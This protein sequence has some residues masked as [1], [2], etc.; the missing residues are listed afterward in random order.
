MSKTVSN[1]SL[2]LVLHV[3]VNKEEKLARV[4]AR[5]QS[6]EHL[7]ERSVSAYEC[8]TSTITRFTMHKMTL[9]K[10]LSIMSMHRLVAGIIK[11]FSQENLT[12]YQ[13][14][15][16]SNT[17]SRQYDKIDSFSI[18]PLEELNL[19]TFLNHTMIK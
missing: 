3:A 4:F 16:I 15:V 2:F 9:N 1:A 7:P 10:R 19:L 11:T 17:T 5:L 6:K 14:M 18:Q 13:A 12:K 8:H